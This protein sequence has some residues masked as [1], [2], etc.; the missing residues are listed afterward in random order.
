MAVQYV[1]NAQDIVSPEADRAG[2]LAGASIGAFYFTDDTGLVYRKSVAGAWQLVNGLSGVS[3]PLALAFHGE[4]DGSTTAEQLPNKAGTLVRITAAYDNAG[5]V[6]IGKSGV[7]KKDGTLDT[8]TGVPIAAGDFRWF[9]VSAN[10]NELYQ[11]A[12]NATD[13]LIYEV[14]A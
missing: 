14:Y 13:D 6:Y 2:A 4:V 3:Q 1:A 9:F 11:I 10:L 7:T 5:Y 8:T 12:D